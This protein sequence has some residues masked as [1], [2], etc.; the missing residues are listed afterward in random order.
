MFHVFY[1]SKIKGVNYFLRQI[2]LLTK[3]V[4][5]L[6]NDKDTWTMSVSGTP[7]ATPD[8]TFKDKEEF[9]EDCKILIKF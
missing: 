1:N 3:P 7:R 6:V 5:K 9:I 2:A 4:I 8:V